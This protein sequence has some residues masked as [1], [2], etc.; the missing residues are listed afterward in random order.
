MWRVGQVANDDV[1]PGPG[2]GQG[3]DPL[4]GDP[5]GDE[6]RDRRF[7]GR[8]LLGS[9][10]EVTEAG[11][12]ASG[13]GRRGFDRSGRDVGN[14]GSA[15]VDDLGQIAQ[16]VR[17]ETDDGVGPENAAGEGDRCVVLSHMD[18]VSTDLE[19][20]VRSIIDDEGHSVGAADV[21]DEAAPL[22]EFL[23]FEV[24][25][26]QLDDVHPS[27]DAR[28]DEVFEVRTIGCAEIQV[29]L[30]DGAPLRHAPARALAFIACLWARTLAK[31]SGPVMSATDR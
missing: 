6:D 2:P 20:H 14:V 21:A 23:G 1:V 16:A 17:R 31:L 8:H 3:G 7:C 26:A 13:F 12:R 10:L 5:A 19:G 11:A 4:G 9:R 22:D 27:S 24:L 18:T 29:A 28:P 15:R 25:L 30:R